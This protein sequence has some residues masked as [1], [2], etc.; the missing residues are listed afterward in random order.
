VENLEQSEPM[1]EIEDF[2]LGKKVFNSIT[3]DKHL[4][5]G[6]R[7]A[8]SAELNK[9]GFIDDVGW[10]GQTPA[11][12]RCYVMLPIPVQTIR[13]DRDFSEEMQEA[14]AKPGHIIGDQTLKP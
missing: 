10:I 3:Q 12:I 2:E 4:A 7:G 8:A 1:I 9:S 11:L 14:S 5:R 13:F 6:I